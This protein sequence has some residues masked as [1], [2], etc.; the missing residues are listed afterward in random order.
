MGI[1]A[2]A[3]AGEGRKEEWVFHLR[4]KFSKIWINVFF[5]TTS[6]L[7]CE[8]VFHQ[9]SISFANDV[10]GNILPRRD[11]LTMLNDRCTTGRRL[12]RHVESERKFGGV[13][14]W[15][16]SESERKFKYR[17]LVARE[18]RA[19]VRALRER[20]SRLSSCSSP[21]R[22]KNKSMSSMNLNL[23]FIGVEDIVHGNAS[24]IRI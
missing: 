3:T 4:A 11:F 19:G 21:G 5:D 14:L 1:S 18:I 22:E 23:S 9:F 24:T 13:N 10:V 8:I 6:T 12:V 7:V 17:N 16:H 20:D 2:T 15:L